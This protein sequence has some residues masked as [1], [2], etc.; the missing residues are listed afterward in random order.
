MSPWQFSVRGILLNFF[1]LVITQTV[2]YRARELRVGGVF[3]LTIG[4][5]NEQGWAGSDSYNDSLHKCAQVLLTLEELLL[6]TITIYNRSFAECVDEQRF[7]RMFIEIDQRRIASNSISSVRS[8]QN[9]QITVQ[10]FARTLTLLVRTWPESIVKQ[11]IEVSASP[12]GE[13]D[14]TL[15]EFWILYEKEV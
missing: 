12:D 10:E 11:T 1:P 6:C 14:E 7:Y 3:I 5:L 13:V 9:G 2:Q 15:A 8:I 4:S